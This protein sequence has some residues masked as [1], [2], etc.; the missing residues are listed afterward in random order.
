MT[1]KQA[2]SILLVALSQIDF[3][4]A[5][6]EDAAEQILAALTRDIRKGCKCER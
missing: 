5:S 6:R 3:D 1:E 4:S 2:L